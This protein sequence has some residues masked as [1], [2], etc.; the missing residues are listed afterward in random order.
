MHAAWGSLKASGGVH[1]PIYLNWG[2]GHL[3]ARLG[4]GWGNLRASARC[5]SSLQ[6]AHP[7]PTAPTTDCREWLHPCLP[8]SLLFPPCLPCTSV[9]RAEHC[10]HAD[11]LLGFQLGSQ[12]GRRQE[13]AERK[14]RMCSEARTPKFPEDPAGPYQTSMGSSQSFWSSPSV[15][16]FSLNLPFTYHPKFSSFSL[17]REVKPQQAR[18]L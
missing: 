6:G 4:H 18:L 16:V 11:G 10:R 7:A 1:S 15:E 8:H 12:V 17:L 2:R 13:A 14:A 3:A 5:L 9:C